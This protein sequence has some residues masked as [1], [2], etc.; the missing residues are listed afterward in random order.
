MTR[1]E[2]QAKLTARVQAMTT[3][4]LLEVSIRLTLAYTPEEIIVC[5]ACERELEQRLPEAA[6]IAHMEA[7][8]AL[9][10]AA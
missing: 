9:L 6:F 7:C 1:T 5:A 8:E 10:D 3:E 4:Q 2:A